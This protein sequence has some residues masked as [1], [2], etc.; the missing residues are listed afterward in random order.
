MSTP[1]PGASSAD[2]RDDSTA[3]ARSLAARR[4]RSLASLLRDFRTQRQEQ[5][6]QGGSRSTRVDEESGE[7]NLSEEEGEE[8]PARFDTIDF[9]AFQRAVGD[10]VK[11]EG[12][13]GHVI[14]P[15]AIKDDMELEYV[16]DVLFENQ[17]GAYLLGTAYYSSKVLLPLDPSSFTRPSGS[18]PSA[19]SF[20]VKSN[21]NGNGSTRAISQGPQAE[22]RDRE[23]PPQSNK[24]SYT[25]DT[26]QPPL[27]DWEYLTPWLVNMREGTDELGWRYNAWFKKQGWKSHAGNM[28]WL[29]WVRRREWVRLRRVRERTKVGPDMPDSALQAERR[30]KKLGEVLSGSKAQ[31]VCNILKAFGSLTLDRERLELWQKWLDRSKKDSETWARME[32]ICQDEEAVSLSL[33]SDFKY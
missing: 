5:Q 27:P 2:D 9:E 19:S 18:I 11:I 12:Q 17:R 14:D 13:D 15:E 6:K 7:E 20:S 22:S 25:L 1:P 28:G 32:A 30:E 16:W 24:T 8:Q 33:F 23:P 21:P 31:N 29:G 26:F 10:P 4:R 3:I